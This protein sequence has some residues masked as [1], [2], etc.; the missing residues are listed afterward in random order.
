MYSVAL[1]AA[2]VW[3]EALQVGKY[4]KVLEKLQRRVAIRVCRAYRTVSTAG[5]TI[6]AGLIPMNLL[7]LERKAQFLKIGDKRSRRADTLKKWQDS[8]N[9]YGESAWTKTLIPD[10]ETWVT[11]KH[12]EN[13]FH[14]TQFLTGHG[15]FGIY[16]FRIGRKETS[17]CWFCRDEQDSPEHS[18]IKSVRWNKESDEAHCELGVILS[19]ENVMSEMLASEQKWTV[20][21]SLI[22]KI[23]SQ[24]ESYERRIIRR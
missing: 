11:R 18:I 4:Q 21:A 17:T 5:A 10:I 13:E 15:C 6:I 3:A 9:V 8:W 24:K 22:K 2:P 16:L 12:G 20:I 7:A 1:Y 19:K 14:L 23:L